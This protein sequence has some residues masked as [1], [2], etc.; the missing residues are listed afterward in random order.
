MLPALL[1]SVSAAIPAIPRILKGEFIV[2]SHHSSTDFPFLSNL[3]IS[4]LSS[5]PLR[6]SASI[7]PYSITAAFSQN[8][9]SGTVDFLGTSI[10]FSFAISPP[11]ATT[12]LTLPGNTAVHL[13]VLSPR[14]FHVVV[15][16]NHSATAVTLEKNLSLW[17][18][19]L[20][21]LNWRL[22]VMVSASVIL[23]LALRGRKT[24]PKTD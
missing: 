10:P 7:G 6:L 24:K 1:F 17:E 22:F 23:W 20:P 8:G 9:R 13:S 18:V 21:F 4:Q 11:F 12:D 5:N 2:K 19:I 14:A 16:A 15:S 3:S